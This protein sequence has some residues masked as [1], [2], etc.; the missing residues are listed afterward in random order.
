MNS[1]P[2]YVTTSDLSSTSSS[3]SGFPGTVII[4]PPGGMPRSYTQ[5][6]GPLVAPKPSFLNPNNNINMEQYT[7][8]R[9]N[10]CLAGRSNS[11]KNVLLKHY[12]THNS[13]LYNQIF[14]FC[15]EANLNDDF[16]FI[17]PS[18][19]FDVTRV[20]LIVK[21][22]M[23]Q[24]KLANEGITNNILI[25]ID[26]FI[27]KIDMHSKDGKL[28]NQL[29]SSGRHCGINCCFLTQSINKLS[30]VIRDNIHYWFLCV[31]SL[32]EIEKVFAYNTEISKKK[33][34]KEYYHH[35][36]KSAYHTMMIQLCNPH[37]REIYYLNPVPYS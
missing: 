16:S 8:T 19:K 23:Y 14:V 1:R 27:S 17:P 5:Q 12:L 6:P 29:V 35:W 24:K 37:I 18:R 28:F 32:T 3:S 4:T 20:D 2:K 10:I 11:G 9:G 36:T 26:D 22:Y 7:F 30:N 21:I 15:D 33:T 31:M 13:E 25:I 34:F